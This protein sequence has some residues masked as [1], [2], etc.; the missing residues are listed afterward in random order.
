[1]LAILVVQPNVVHSDSPPNPTGHV[2]NGTS[3]PQVLAGMISYK[4]YCAQCHGRN[5]QGQPLWQIQDADQKRRAPA[6]DDT[7][8]TWQHSDE[9]LIQMVR[10][11]KFPSAP[12]S[13]ASYMPAF[14]EYLNEQ[15]ILE[16]L[17]F[18]KSRWAIGLRASQST[19]NPGYAGM[20]EGSENI[21]WTLPPNCNNGARQ[22]WL[23]SSR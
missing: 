7:G 15:Q 8:H 19:L 16:V 18:I 1:M 17:A 6:Q 3:A 13:A 9:D 20:P 4:T 22:D 2:L 23:K 10:S 21:P 5:L 11:G 14:K 12:A